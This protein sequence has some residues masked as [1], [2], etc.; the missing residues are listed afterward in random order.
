M[1]LLTS[2][3]SPLDLPNKNFTSRWEELFQ[4]AMS[5]KI[6]IGY[7]S[8]DSLLY[9]RKLLELN[10]PKKLDLCLGMAFFEGLSNSQF[11]ATEEL[12][13]FLIEN[14]LGRVKISRAFP[15]HGKVQSFHGGRN[16]KSFLIGS[17]N[18]SNIVPVKGIERRN[19]EVDLEI[20]SLD[21]VTEIDVLLEK[22]FSGSSELFDVIAPQIKI[23][24]G[25][26]PLLA[27]RTDVEHIGDSGLGEIIS[28]LT[29]NSF[30]I[31]LKQAPKSN[32][33]AY[34][35]EGRI[36]QQ[37]FTKP[38][39]WYEVEI[40]VDV[41]VQRSSLNYPAN[42][43]FVV[44][45]DDG[46]KFIMRTSGDYGKNLRSRDDLTILGRWLKGRMEKNG[47]L[48]SGELI[49]IDN[50][51]RYGRNSI[52]FTQTDLTE[53]QDD[54]RTKLNVWYLDFSPRQTVN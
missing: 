2:N 10:Q 48:R 19:Y 51:K 20:N 41:S 36:D 24:E 35:G 16:S 13:K 17:S 29:K 54:S 27:S 1:Q 7:A 49:T 11:E 34:F 5:I 18:L 3:F 46:Y 30:E 50:F 32:L 22:L 40:I 31:P 37:G 38:R 26:N 4:D 21:K 43:D 45:T 6:G 23:R 12:D 44:Y 33:N 14:K 15:F 25:D 52:S 39:H 47:A 9:L 28:H 8:N 42:S 53:L